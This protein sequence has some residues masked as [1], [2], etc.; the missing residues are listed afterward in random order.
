MLY[1]T[2]QITKFN[3]RIYTYPYI[4]NTLVYICI[5]TC[6]TS[7]MTH[8]DVWRPVSE[9]TTLRK[10]RHRS[11]VLPCFRY[12]RNHPYMPYFTRSLLLTHRF[13]SLD[14]TTIHISFLLLHGTSISYSVRHMHICKIAVCVCVQKISTRRSALR[15]R[16]FIYTV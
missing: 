2:I 10:C 5:Y 7:T 1:Y 15:G 6:T 11:C 8:C 4:S 13:A 3:D 14:T 9:L 16:S 12:C